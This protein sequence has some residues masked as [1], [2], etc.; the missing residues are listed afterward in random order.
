S[1]GAKEI[2]SSSALV[3]AG[4]IKRQNKIAHRDVVD[5]VSFTLD[6][7]A[8]FE[9]VEDLLALLLRM[10]S[11][12]QEVVF[13]VSGQFQRLMRECNRP[14]FLELFAELQKHDPVRDAGEVAVMI[15]VRV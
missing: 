7:I 8:H 3:A 4:E 14:I 12:H 1:D 9:P 5:L 6:C 15:A 11:L 2:V 13:G 10:W